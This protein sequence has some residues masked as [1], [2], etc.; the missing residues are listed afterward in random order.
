M[1]LGDYWRG[2]VDVRS[3]LGQVV[4]SAKE[5]LDEAAA[6]SLACEFSC[7]TDFLAPLD[8]GGGRLIAPVPPSSA[9]SPAPESGGLT[10]RLARALADA[11]AG[12]WRPWL[13]RRTNA[14]ARMRDSPPGN[15][16]ARA[17]AAGYEITEP[18]AGRHVVLV[19]DVILTGSTVLAIA[20]RLR[21]AH[22][23]SVTAAVAAKT[24]L[25]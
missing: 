14:T 8:D 1:V 11:A 22:A 16:A 12:E 6:R 10:A 9:V 3:A 25:R 20:A 15:R 13:V 7:L 18:V 19:D 17:E 23:A 4:F 21:A 2:D 5:Q 24:R